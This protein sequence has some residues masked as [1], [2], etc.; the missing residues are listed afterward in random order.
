MEWNKLPIRFF[1]IITAPRI[2]FKQPSMSF[3]LT[4]LHI[5]ICMLVYF[6][7]TI[8][9]ATFDVW[10]Q[11][12]KVCDVSWRV[13]CE[14][15]GA[16]EGSNCNRSNIWNSAVFRLYIWDVAKMSW[17]L[18]QQH[19]HYN[20]WANIHVM[21]HVTKPVFLFTLLSFF[22]FFDVKNTNTRII[23]VN[24]NLN[25]FTQSLTS[26]LTHTD[27]CKSVDTAHAYLL[28]TFGRFF[29]SPVSI[30]AK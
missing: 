13:W 11:K 20:R 18:A 22:F 29:Y 10:N 19:W 21:Q 5:N 14:K 24:M 25:S 15:C 23:Y 16:N 4:T 2:N 1:L 30:N 27:P 17:L 7:W 6:F 12:G 8:W 9:N 3:T 26:P 28:I